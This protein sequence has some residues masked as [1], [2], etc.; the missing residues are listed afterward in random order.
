MLLFILGAVRFHMAK[1]LNGPKLLI[2]V[3][4]NCP[5]S[6]FHG[7]GMTINMIHLEREANKLSLTHTHT[8]THTRQDGPT[9]ALRAYCCCFFVAVDI[10]IN[11]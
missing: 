3:R 1:F 11:L 9:T 8:H 6:K 5:W 2:Q 7:A 4:V 10:F